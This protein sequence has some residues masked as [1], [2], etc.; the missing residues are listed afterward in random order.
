MFSELASTRPTA[1]TVR[2]KPVVGGG[3]GG[4]VDVYAER[5]FHADVAAKINATSANSGKP[6]F[7]TSI[8]LLS[9]FS[10]ETQ[11][12]RSPFRRADSTFTTR[13]SSIR[14]MVSAKVKMRLS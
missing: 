8:S 6:N 5:H 10:F 4:G 7:F 1:P 14:A 2:S 3:S 13:P 11:S 12:A 9:V